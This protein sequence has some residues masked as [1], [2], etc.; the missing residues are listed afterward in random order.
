MHSEHGTVSGWHCGL[1]CPGL[2]LDR[3]LSLTELG[4]LY[5]YRRIAATLH[6]A[7][8]PSLLI[9]A[10]PDSRAG[11]VKYALYAFWLL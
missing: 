4:D 11:R 3:G 2:L 7:D 8:R 10:Q 6:V 1:G 5:C 9:K